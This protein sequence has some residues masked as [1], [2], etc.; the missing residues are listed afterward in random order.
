MKWEDATKRQQAPL[1][2]Q[3]YTHLLRTGA[4]QGQRAPDYGLVLLCLAS[5][6][7]NLLPHPGPQGCS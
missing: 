6:S 4:K 1:H 7:Q 3:A 2:I 5:A